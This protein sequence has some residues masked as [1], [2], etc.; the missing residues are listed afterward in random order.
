MPAKLTFLSHSAFLVESG[1]HA[2]LIDPFLTGNPQAPD[3]PEF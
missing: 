1:K 2:V 3:A